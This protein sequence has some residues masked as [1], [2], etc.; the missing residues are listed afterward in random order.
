MVQIKIKVIQEAYHIYVIFE[1]F[2]IFI[3]EFKKRLKA[4]LGNETRCFE[5]FFHIQKISSKELKQLF[6][7]CEHYHTIILGINYVPLQSVTNYIEEDLRGG[8]QYTF[9]EDTI[10]LGNIHKQAFVACKGNL[11]VI[12][13][14]AG[15]VDF[16]YEDNFL[17]ASKIEASVRI[18]DTSYQNMTC[19]APCKVYYKNRCLIISDY[20]EDKQWERQ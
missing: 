13:K 5:A 19:Y 14:V 15:S 17:C 10:L 11:Y 1:D 16:L 7:L 2:D 8:E 12:G 6:V 3:N 18:C 9:S 4:I 20:K